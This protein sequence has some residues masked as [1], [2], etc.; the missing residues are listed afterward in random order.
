MRL[1][2]QF[3]ENKFPNFKVSNDSYNKDY[4]TIFLKPNLSKSALKNC[5]AE[6][7]QQILEDLAIDHAIIS[8]EI[9]LMNRFPHLH[10]MV[11]DNAVHVWVSRNGKDGETLGSVKK[12]GDYL[13]KMEVFEDLAYMATNLNGFIC[14]DCFKIWPMNEFE[15][16]V[17]AAKYCKTCCN[18]QPELLKEIELFKK[19]GY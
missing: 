18:K 17:G 3:L 5:S 13:K 19:E 14:N 10:V 11:H 7:Q 12:D 9:E 2:K 8:E 16:I 4:L 15:G 6:Y 1:T